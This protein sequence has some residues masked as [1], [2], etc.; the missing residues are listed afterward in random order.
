MSENSEPKIYVSGLP[1]DVQ[2]SDLEKAFGSYGSITD[3]YVKPKDTFAFAFVTFSSMDEAQDAI[4]GMS[5]R[6]ICGKRVRIDIAK[7]RQRNGG[8]R[9]GNDNRGRGGDRPRGRGCF[10][11]NQEGHFAR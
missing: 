4:Q 8:D 5:G 3:V 10:K 2:N 9:G 7:P 11:C 6:S 1:V